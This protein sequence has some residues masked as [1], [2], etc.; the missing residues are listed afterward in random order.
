MMRALKLCSVGFVV[1]LLFSNCQAAPTSLETYVMGPYTVEGFGVT[2]SEAKADAN[3]EMFLK[4]QEI[5]AGLPHNH[6]YLD[7]EVISEGFVNESTYEI[8]FNVIIWD[9]TPPG[10]PNG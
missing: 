10:P 9:K 8:N 2:P 6:E 7:F 3:W 5:E 4:I 1:L